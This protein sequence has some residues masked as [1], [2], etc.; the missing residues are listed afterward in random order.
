MLPD[1]DHA[2]RQNALRAVEGREGFR[3]ARHLAADRRLA[4]DQNHFDAAGR[5]VERRLNPGHARAYDHRAF[6]NGHF[7]RLERGVAAHFR[8]RDSDKLDRLG[9]RDRLVA[10][11]PR[12]LLADI[13]HL[14]H[15]RV[16]ARKLDRLAERLQ[17]HV[18]GAARNDDAR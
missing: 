2:R 18:R 17:V 11:Y 7:N 14:D 3:K 9:G 12:A 8:D 10:V 15:V 13:R 5:K 4:F 6:R 1:F 16:N